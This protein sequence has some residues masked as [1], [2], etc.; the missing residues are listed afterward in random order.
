[1]S[2]DITPSI[3][4]GRQ[5]VQSYGDHRF[6]ISNEVFEMPVLVFPDETIPWSVTSIDDLSIASLSRVIEADPPVEIFLIGCGKGMALIPPVL[7]D[8]LK[9][10]G[11]VIEPMDTGAACR[12]FN[13]LT[14]EDRR[15]AAALI[16]VE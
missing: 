3:P 6:T 15:V 9:A 16:P 4:I 12:T 8:E 2:L 11:I 5:I 1:M 10:A 14:T 7:R 13:V